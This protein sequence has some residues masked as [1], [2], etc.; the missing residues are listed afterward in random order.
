VERVLVMVLV[1]V[2]VV[3]Q[4]VTQQAVLALLV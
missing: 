4:T 1:A 3:L 2:A